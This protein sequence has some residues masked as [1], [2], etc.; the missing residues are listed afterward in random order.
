MQWDKYYRR[1]LLVLVVAVFTSLGAWAQEDFRLELES[2][3]AVQSLRDGLLVTPLE[4]DIGGLEISEGDVSLDGEVLG[5]RTLE[6]LLG[7]EKSA[8]LRRLAEYSEEE[9]EDLFRE[10]SGEVEE[11]LEEEFRVVEETDLSGLPELPELP[12]IPEVPEIP[13]IRELTESGRVSV[14]AAV[15]IEEDQVVEEAVSVGGPLV[16]AGTVLGD[17]V[18]VGSSAEVSGTV[19]GD[20]VAIGGSIYLESSAVIEGVATSVGGKVHRDDGAEV[21]SIQE[22][23]LLGDWLGVLGDLDD[24]DIDWNDHEYSSSRS[25]VK[26]LSE[27]FRSIVLWLV[28]AVIGAV[29]LAVFGDRRFRETSAVVAE[30]P[31]RALGVGFFSALVFFP[32]LLVISILL[33]V[34]LIGIPVFLILA[35]VAIVVF[36]AAAFFGYFTVAWQVGQWAKA[37]FNWK[38]APY[39]VLAAGLF[40]LQTGDLLGEFT[41]VVD[42][43]A[44]FFSIATGL[45]GFMGWVVQ[46]LAVL[47]GLGGAIV[48]F[49]RGSSTP[50]LP[51]VPLSEEEN[52]GPTYWE[53]GTDSETGEYPSAE[54]AWEEKEES[55]TEDDPTEAEDDGFFHEEEPA[56]S[57][58]DEFSEAKFSEVEGS[59]AVD[60]EDDEDLFSES[61]V[62][63]E[64]DKA[65][66]DDSLGSELD[67]SEEEERE[68]SG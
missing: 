48:Y 41:D 58:F 65:Q 19:E 1:A 13:D 29:I 35:P 8:L 11:S 47:V 17:S 2:Q 60:N 49:M 9:L 42:G 46:C 56:S 64:E 67:S 45:F 57:E 23:N 15:V 62:D 55:W 36:F 50:P 3:F 66:D 10:E 30:S 6:A 34:T 37:R 22:V 18:V 5:E 20:L 40:L 12:E 4:G 43:T 33:V 21:G 25:Y 26:T 53:E 59:D 27:F 32:V 68:T 31:L 28:L 39:L 61:E 63:E 51:P 14:G 38:W 16:I 24:L 54:N 44:D 52:S 7:V